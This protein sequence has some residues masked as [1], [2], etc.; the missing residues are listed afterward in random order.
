MKSQ[1]SM[2]G[3]GLGEM[4]GIGDD[5]GS[6]I[7]QNIPVNPGKHSQVTKSLSSSMHSPLVHLIKSHSETLAIGVGETRIELEGADVMKKL[8]LSGTVLERINAEDGGGREE[9]GRRTN[10]ELET[11]AGELREGVGV[12]KGTRRLSEL[13]M[14]NSKDE[15]GSE[16]VGV[17]VIRDMLGMMDTSQ[18][19]PVNPAKHWH[20][21][22]SPKSS[23]KHVPLLQSMRSQI[24]IG[25]LGEGVGVIDVI[26]SIG[27]SQ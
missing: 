26:D 18:K 2:G 24:C 1:T 8:E 9:E 5:E 12:S 27:T 17:G 23:A 25:G 15:N 21:K 4:V 14:T 7:S 16:L 11:E 20:V 13:E 19:S 6:G 3:L 22:L 10:S